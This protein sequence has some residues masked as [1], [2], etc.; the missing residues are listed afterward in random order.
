MCNVL[1]LAGLFVCLGDLLSF[2]VVG[3]KGG[4]EGVTDKIA[5]LWFA[6]GYQYTGWQ[7][8]CI[9]ITSI[10]LYLLSICYIYYIK[11]LLFIMLWIYIYYRDIFQDDLNL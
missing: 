9:L 10:K 8:E 5:G 4:R 11:V 3:G 7:C 6:R 2:S 1:Q